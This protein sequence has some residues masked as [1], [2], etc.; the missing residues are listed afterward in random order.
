MAT[1]EDDYTRYRAVGDIPYAIDDKIGRSDSRDRIVTTSMTIGTTATKI[2]DSPLGRRDFIRIK[3]TDGANSV[4]VL[5][6]SGTTISGG[7]PVAAGAEWE[8]NTDAEFWGIVETGTIDIEV[9]ERSG[10]FN[11]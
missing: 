4:Y 9:Y 5:T 1:K 11:Y 3:N 10:R 2:P 7:Y 8:E 6:S